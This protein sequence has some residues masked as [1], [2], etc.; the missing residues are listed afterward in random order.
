MLKKF[1]E[2]VGEALG[3]ERDMFDP[4]VLGDPVAMQTDW[5][6]AKFG[7]THFRTHK[8]V[9]SNPDRLEFRA[10]I[11]AKL[12][13]ILFL[14][15]EIAVVVVIVFFGRFIEAFAPFWGPIIPIGAGVAC[16]IVG[17]CMYYFGT[18]PIVFDRRRGFFWNTRK[19]PDHVFDKGTLKHFAK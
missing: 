12:Y 1:M 19:N 17:A 18:A 9:E 11:R 15:V 4:S 6:P 5:T 14:G 16:T 7:G 13:Y 3:I 8:L 10:T 2:K